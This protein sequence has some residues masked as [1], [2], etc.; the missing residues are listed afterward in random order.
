MVNLINIAKL[1]V[2]S[3]VN[4]EVFQ[5]ITNN[6]KKISIV[7]SV[8]ITLSSAMLWN[9]SINVILFGEVIIIAIE[10]F[11]KTKKI[12][13][14]IACSVAFIISFILYI[15]TSEIS[16]IICFAYVFLALDIWV[17]L[18]NLKE[19]KFNK[20]DLV[21]IIIS[22]LIIAVC[23]FYN[24][25]SLKDTVTGGQGIGY[26]F[27]Y[28]YS[29][30]LPFVQT[31]NNMAYASFLSFFPIPLIMGMIY[32]YKEEKHIEFILPILIVLVLESIWCMTGFPNILSNMT[33][34]SRVSVE[35]C[36]MAIGLA[37][38]YLYLYMI[39]NIKENFISLKDAVKITLIVLVLFFCIDRPDVLEAS[40]GYMYLFSSILSMGYFLILNSINKKYTNLFLWS[41][42][43][44]TL[45]SSVPALFI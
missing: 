36:A 37:C 45:I 39:A 40:K 26:L 9:L 25:I 31:E 16:Y 42:V 10:K 23:I 21:Y 17:V 24:P 30:M 6:N 15:F 28:G 12:S 43:I 3:I 18:K 19:Y 41:A 11:M 44:W 35:K 34:F 8:L 4:F 14:K 1:I 22:I 20:L 38:I 13:L 33:L 29:Y 7:G 27:S 5:I 32:I 2:L